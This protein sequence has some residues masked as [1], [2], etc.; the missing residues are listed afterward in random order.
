M[1]GMED[2]EQFTLDYLKNNDELFYIEK[3][4]CIEQLFINRKGDMEVCDTFYI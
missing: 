3:K 4:D 1:G 2:A